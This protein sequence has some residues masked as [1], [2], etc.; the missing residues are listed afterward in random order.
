MPGKEAD[1]DDEAK[2]DG[3][4]DDD[5]ARASGSK[6]DDDDD[7]LEEDRAVLQAVFDWYYASD[8]LEETLQKWAEA[9]CDEFNREAVNPR[10]VKEYKLEHT[11]LHDEFK[12]L[13]EAR[14]EAEVRKRGCSVQR[15]YS[16]VASDRRSPATELCV[17]E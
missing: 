6:H 9:H 12:Q 8:E 10:G 1:S 17:C 4:H 14:L 16:I 2:D 3:K 15:F 11:R 5:F 7:D 13:F